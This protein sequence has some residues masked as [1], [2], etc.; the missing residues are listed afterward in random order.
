MQKGVLTVEW[1]GSGPSKALMRELAVKRTLCDP[2][3]G[4]NIRLAVPKISLDQAAG[5]LQ[6]SDVRGA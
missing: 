5:S 3:N 6:V 2:A 1:P 4:I